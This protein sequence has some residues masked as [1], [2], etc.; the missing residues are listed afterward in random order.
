MDD[1]TEV[2][3]IL[4]DF[5]KILEESLE[6]SLIFHQNQQAQK[7]TLTVSEIITIVNFFS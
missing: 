1:I 3:C 4:N 5:C 2:F 6:K 7:S